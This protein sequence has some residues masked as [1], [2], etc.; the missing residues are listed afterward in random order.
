MSNKTAQLVQKD[1]K[2]VWHP[3]TQMQDWE[4]D[5]IL[6][7]EEG[8]GSWLKDTEG[9]WY[10]DGISSLWVNVHGH[11]KKE[12][13]LAMQQQ[14]KK[15]AHSTLLG[16]SN[17]PAIRLAE[18]LIQIAPKGLKK[19][20]Y[21]DSG[22]TAV[23]IAL[24]MAFQY[25]QQKEGGKKKKRFLH[26]SNAY[27]GDTLG[28]ASVG[29]IDLFHEM[30]APLMIPSYETPA[31]HCY[32]CRLTKHPTQSDFLKV[33]GN[34]ARTNPPSQNRCQWECVESL[35]QILSKRSEELAAVI[36]EPIMQGAAGMH[37]APPG[38]LKQVRQACTKYG[39]LLIVDEVA[40]GFGRT[41]KMFACELESV[42]P[43]LMAVA[44]GL[45]GGTLPL[46]A[47]LTTNEVYQA[48]KGD[49][50]EKKTF[51]HGHTYTGNP[52]AC[53]AA[54]KNLELFEK[55]KTI[56]KLKPKIKFLE[57][58]LRRFEALEFVGE[59]RQ[60][61]MMVGVELVQNKKKKNPFDWEKRVGARVCQQARSQG[62][63]LRPLGDVVV[64]MPPLTISLP[65]LKKLLK[66][67]FESIT[68][69]CEEVNR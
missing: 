15:C 49:Y 8:K 32:R 65:E 38:F 11:R 57:K 63:L 28:S 60:A 46:A 19:V 1:K 42:T 26:L 9:N 4:Q 27:H 59:V 33:S 35:K 31:P 56:K 14:I 54:L 36:V 20:F 25:W 61:G 44:K 62:V 2:Y 3:F 29:G 47:T 43:D 24:K 58:E 50:G 7:I 13:D 5:N 40:T 55:E 64:L 37:V 48:F 34:C 16:L 68:L 51:F 66:V 39:I 53:A 10:L 67:T 22:S 69:V 52:L 41:G 18:K 30:Y 12:I 17:E 6:V 21:S 23:E 45:S